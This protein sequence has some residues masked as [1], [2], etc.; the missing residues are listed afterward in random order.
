[1]KLKCNVCHASPIVDVAKEPNH[2]NDLVCCPSC[3]KQL[4][5]ATEKNYS[6]K[7]IWK[8]IDTEYNIDLGFSPVEIIFSN[9]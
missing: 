3:D 2:T 7:L 5:Y 6:T 4:A 9:N 8:P 1:M